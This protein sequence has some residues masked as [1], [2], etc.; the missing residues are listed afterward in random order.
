MDSHQAE[1]D[2][3]RQS[4]WNFIFNWFVK[5]HDWG[6]QRNAGRKNEWNFSLDWHQAEIDEHYRMLLDK[7][8]DIFHLVDSHQADI[9]KRSRMVVG[10]TN[11]IS[12]W[13][14]SQQAAINEANQKLLE[15]KQCNFSF[16]FLLTGLN[17]CKYNHFTH[18]IE[19]AKAVKRISEIENEIT[20]LKQEKRGSR[21]ETPHQLD[22]TNQEIADQRFL[23]SLRDEEM[24]R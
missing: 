5:S 4:Q 10:K 19:L 1:I 6:A 11:A 23:L 2:A 3:I 20:I 15:K 7:I 17:H 18:F 16:S 12:H 9:D 22:Q 21:E 24:A 8:N 13:V 14:D